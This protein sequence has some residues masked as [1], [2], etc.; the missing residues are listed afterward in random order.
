MLSLSCES[1]ITQVLYTDSLGP[2]V[3]HTRLKK[4][5]LV[6][7]NTV[8]YYLYL[9]LISSGVLVSRHDGVLRV[10][11]CAAVHRWSVVSTGTG[12]D[13]AVSLAQSPLQT[14]SMCTSVHANVGYS[15][16]VHHFTINHYSLNVGTKD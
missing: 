9:Q 13:P 16:H 3:L 4:P 14:W 7:A 6:L 5:C 1:N 12:S 15:I 10:S 2:H 11:V 8:T